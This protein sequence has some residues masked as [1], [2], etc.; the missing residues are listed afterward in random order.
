MTIAIFAL[1]S[2]TSSADATSYTVTSYTPTANRLLL[3]FIATRG[4]TANPTL[5]GNSVTWEVVG[6]INGITDGRLMVF[7]ALSGT[8]SS[9]GT[10]LV[11][12]GVGN[13][14]TGQLVSI[15]EASGVWSV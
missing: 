12:Y 4:A 5:T 9:A 6:A 7:A 13:T 10:L 1:Q 2:Y 8:G 15:M 11:D 14:Q 3:A